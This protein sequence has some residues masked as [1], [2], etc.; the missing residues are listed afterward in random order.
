SCRESFPDKLCP[1]ASSAA[2]HRA[3]RDSRRGGSAVKASSGRRPARL[4]GVAGLAMATL[5]AGQ[6][7][8]PFEFRQV[9]LDLPVRILPY[10]PTQRRAEVAAEAA[11]AR[12]AQLD[13][14]MSD[15]R[16]N[17]ELRRLETNAGEWTP[18]SPD[19]LEVLAMATSIARATDGAFDPTVGPLVALWRQARETKRMP[20]SADIEAARALVSWKLLEV[21]R[22]RGAVRLAKRGMRLDLG[23]IAKG[24]ILGQGLLALRSAGLGRALIESGGDII[25]GSGP[26]GEAGWR[27]DVPDAS[28]DFTRRARQLTNA[29]VATSGA[30]EQFVDIDGVRYSHVVDPRSGIGVTHN[31]TA[32][33]IA[34]QG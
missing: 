21:D 14:L 5:G 15:Y 19:L 22:R 29:A 25:V 8:Q 17:S 34:D 16:E 4:A 2:R 12:I 3:S 11:F 23:G 31:V 18:I 30:D 27:V 13:A 7:P 32:R 10:A 9:H 1:E 20:A 28:S 26:P 6:R 24:Y 33:V